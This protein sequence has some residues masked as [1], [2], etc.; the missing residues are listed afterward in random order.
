MRAFN[1]LLREAVEE[2]ER[3]NIKLSIEKFRVA[4]KQSPT[5][6]HNLRVE[7]HIGIAHFLL[8]EYKKALYIFANNVMMV[9]KWAKGENPDPDP[10]FEAECLRHASRPQ[11]YEEEMMLFFA[12]KGAKDA[13]N[14]ALETERTDLP[15]FSDGVL[16][17]LLAIEETTKSKL[18][19][20]WAQAVVDLK[21]M[22]E[23]EKND[24][25]KWGW[26]VGILIHKAMIEKDLSYL[27]IA[28][29]LANEKNLERRKEEVDKVRQ[30][31]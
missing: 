17:N 1:K 21:L 3:G 9:R 30:D 14:L 27:E 25:A 2:R 15:W 24:L 23:K 12:L 11:L 13:R 4:Q 19:E 6:K 20:A 29:I 18:N 8:S 26:L 28:E 31:L 7:N 16:E 22:W 5:F 10:S